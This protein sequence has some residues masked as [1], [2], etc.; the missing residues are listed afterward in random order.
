M[1]QAQVKTIIPEHLD[2]RVIAAKGPTTEIINLSNMMKA[3]GTTPYRYVRAS[4]KKLIEGEYAQAMSWLDYAREFCGV[5]YTVNSEDDRLFRDEITI[6]RITLLF[7]IEKFK[8]L[9]PEE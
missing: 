8:E 1:N 5:F 6:L 3:S 7:L 9:K 2:P 4:L